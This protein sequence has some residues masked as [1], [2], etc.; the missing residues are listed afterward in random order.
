[1]AYKNTVLPIALSSIN[2]ATFTGSYQLL[3]AAAGLPNACV[4]LHIVNNSDVSITIS[5][6]GTTDHDFLL[7]TSDRELAFQSNANP[8]AFAA[9]LA[10][11]TKV[12]V[13][14]SAGTGLV[15]LSGWYQPTQ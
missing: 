12:Y 13:K 15:Y 5:Y 11:G 1:M 4:M 6:N 7:P 2:S 9:S 14:G 10:Q 3:S 8:Q